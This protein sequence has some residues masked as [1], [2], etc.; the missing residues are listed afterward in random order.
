MGGVSC[1]QRSESLIDEQPSVERIG[2]IVPR[3]KLQESMQTYYAGTG[4]QAFLVHFV[5]EDAS[6]TRAVILEVGTHGIGLA[7][8]RSF[9]QFKAFR[10]EVSVQCSLSYIQEGT[11]LCRGP[12][13]LVGWH[14]S[15]IEFYFLTAVSSM[16]VSTQNM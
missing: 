13:D 14:N 7:K 1:R 11:P 10:F 15:E 6:E 2:V 4:T 5:N 3:G 12:Q 8:P 16:H 9:E